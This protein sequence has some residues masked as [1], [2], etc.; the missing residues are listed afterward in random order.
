MRSRSWRRRSG[1]T[2][3]QSDR[4]AGGADAAAAHGDRRR[5]LKRPSAFLTARW[6]CCP[7]RVGA[8]RCRRE[9]AGC[10]RQRS[11]RGRRATAR[12]TAVNPVK[13]AM[14]AIA[15]RGRDGGRRARA[16]R[17]DHGAPRG[18]PPAAAHARRARR[19][20]AALRRRRSD[21][22]RR[23]PDRRLRGAG[24]PLGRGSR[25][26]V[27]RRRPRGRAWAWAS[28]WS[29]ELCR[30]ARR[31]GFCALCA[32]AHDPAFFVRLGFSIVPH[33]WVPEKIAHDCHVCPLFRN[34][35]QY[36]MVLDLE[37]PRR[38]L[39]GPP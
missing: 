37:G 30:R 2:A 35:G 18:G 22:P 26:A 19:A 28:A 24:A 3:R 1:G 36:A 32:F 5:R 12:R 17:A 21:R 29:N 16:A 9:H 23:R 6:R 8:S 38:T 27:A 34:C 31:E 13:P 11:D 4:R 10:R 39:C 14:P 20:R 25:G 7:R 15:V 33:T